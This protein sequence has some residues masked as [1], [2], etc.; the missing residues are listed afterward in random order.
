M[1]TVHSTS[2][3]MTMAEISHEICPGPRSARTAEEIAIASIGALLPDKYFI[4]AERQFR[5][6]VLS[7]S[8]PV[9]ISIFE[10][11]SFDERVACAMALV[12]DS[13]YAT[14][15]LSIPPGFCAKKIFDSK[16]E[17]SSFAA[18]FL[19]RNLEG[20]L[21]PAQQFLKTCPA[22]LHLPNDREVCVPSDQ[23]QAMVDAVMLKVST[24]AIPADFE[25]K[26]DIKLVEHLN[27]VIDQLS[28]ADH[29]LSLLLSSPFLAR[30]Q[31]K[32]VMGPFVYLSCFGISS[33]ASEVPPLSSEPGVGGLGPDD[34]TNVGHSELEGSEAASPQPQGEPGE[35][36]DSLEEGTSATVVPRPRRTKH[37][38][39]DCFTEW[40]DELKRS[41]HQNFTYQRVRESALDAFE[42]WCVSYPR[43]LAPPKTTGRGGRSKT[44]RH[45]TRSHGTCG[46]FI[47]LITSTAG[48]AMLGVLRHNHPL[49]QSVLITSE[50]H[51]KIL[52]WVADRKKVA[53][54]TSASRLIKELEDQINAWD[55]E[56]AKDKTHW[57][58][59]EPRTDERF[60]P[61]EQTIRNLL[62][63]LSPELKVHDGE[64]LIYT[65]ADFLHKSKDEALL[66]PSATFQS[67][68]ADF[69]KPL[70]RVFFRQGG[71][72]QNENFLL[73][74]QTV[75]MYEMMARFGDHV[76]M[77]ST[78]GTTLYGLYL[79]FVVL[80]DN[81][82]RVQIAAA[83]I[84]AEQNTTIIAEALRTLATWSANTWRPKYMTMDCATAEWA[85][86]RE[87]FPSTEIILCSWHLVDA[88]WRYLRTHVEDSTSRDRINA[89]FCLLRFH[90][91]KD[92]YDKKKTK[93]LSS[94]DSRP[95]LK[96]YFQNVWFLREKN[97]AHAFRQKPS[98]ALDTNNAAEGT[99]SKQKKLF[100]WKGSKSVTAVVRTL[101]YDSNIKYLTEFL[102][103]NAECQEDSDN[104]RHYTHDKITDQTYLRL[105]KQVRHGNLIRQARARE[106]A[107]QNR[108]FKLVEGGYAV[109]M[110]PYGVALQQARGVAEE[111]CVYNLNI[112]TGECE[113]PFYRYN[114]LPCKHLYY[115]LLRESLPWPADA[116]RYW[117]WKDTFEDWGP[118]QPVIARS[119]MDL[120]PAAMSPQAPL[121]GPNVCA[122]IRKASR[123]FRELCEK[124][125]HMGFDIEENAEQLGEQDLTVFLAAHK[126]MEAEMQRV[127]LLRHATLPTI[128]TT[129][130]GQARRKHHARK[131]S[132]SEITSR[133]A[134]I[135]AQSMQPP[136]ELV[137]RL[138]RPS[139]STRPRM[140]PVDHD[141]DSDNP[142]SSSDEDHAP[143]A[144][145]VPIPTATTQAAP[146]VAPVLG[147]M[148]DRSPTKRRNMP[149]SRM[150]EAW[151][152]AEM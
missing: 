94:L 116:F 35:D 129:T 137:R 39:P 64:A 149:S 131:K 31:D 42:Y 143:T 86:V 67:R 26:F 115:I 53:G 58:K 147:R 24:T 110:G 105:P 68:E 74:M 71:S 135:L 17:A 92:Q 3:A 9:T 89:A 50:P 136:Q 8:I 107:E 11:L 43:K 66:M 124:G 114:M 61:K 146:E 95:E 49:N 118:T 56:A 109:R 38:P 44:P 150:L 22:Y 99:N 48:V 6:A 19:A 20:H 84:T 1:G 80:K 97:W 51:F 100:A 132:A 93:F 119:Q 27:K 111:D 127:S 141:P 14:K 75:H 46:A 117:H 140:P 36:C 72:K 88:V 12:E 47:K 130:L 138:S 33:A 125:R 112:N 102:R 29:R 34:V 123:A 144:T 151:S 5:K 54:M 52:E 28:Q 134:H 16:L 133:R 2:S 25:A 108:P 62:A 82:H 59:R 40:I 10:A 152:D 78:H 145:P 85:A 76:G 15:K 101:L 21:V 69:G 7:V 73:V 57:F 83:F 70:D 98:M 142:S 81:H 41:E 37:E 121:P 139:Q 104:R 77:D 60:F 4:Q 96:T 23:L 128:A 87:V 65:L 126:N 55:S 122:E 113:C 79:F 63:V 120:S 91:D 18:L 45:K 90:G 106:L 13:L 103:D 32:G 148:F 30:F